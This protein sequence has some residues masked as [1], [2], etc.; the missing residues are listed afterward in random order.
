VDRNRLLVDE[1]N[2]HD[3][4]GQAFIAPGIPTV[5]LLAPPGDDITPDKFVAIYSDGTS[6]QQGFEG[7]PIR[8]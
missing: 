2:Y 8:V 1:V 7:V 3:D 5:F 6:Q 4:G